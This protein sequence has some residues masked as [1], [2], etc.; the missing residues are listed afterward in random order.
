MGSSLAEGVVR[1]VVLVGSFPFE[2]AEETLT[3]SASGLAGVAGRLTDGEAQGWTTFPGKFMGEVEA[4]EQDEG[5]TQLPNRRIPHFRLKKGIAPEQ[6]H[7]K[8]AG[9]ADLVRAS[10]AIFRRLKEAGRIGQDVR[11]Q[12]SLP[13]PFGVIAQYV[14]KDIEA[15]LPGYEKTLFGE[16]QHICSETPLNELAI[17]WDIAVEVVGALEGHF[18]GLLERFPMERLAALVAKAAAQVPEPT[19]L[20]LHFCYGNPGGKH[21]IEPRDLST[22]VPFC[23]EIFR[24]IPRKVNWVHMPVPIERDDKPYFAA[25]ADLKLAADTEFYLGLIHLRDGLAGG[26]RR[27]EAAKAY[28]KD[29]EIGTECGFRYVARESVPALLELHQQLARVP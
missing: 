27:I 1:P 9:Y 13:T 2:T 24:L 29:F 10:F 6:V 4:L 11:F 22:I 8:P 12:Q 3:V 16:L 5:F 26:R 17:Q 19:E 15:L 14:K 21:I 23:N 28:R 20:G 7:F 18:E 25:L